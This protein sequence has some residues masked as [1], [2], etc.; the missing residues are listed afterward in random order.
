MLQPFDVLQ[1][2]L[3]SPRWLAFLTNWGYLLLVTSSFLDCGLV[4][5]AHLRQNDLLIDKSEMTWYLKLGWILY[6]VSTV[7]SVTITL[8]FYTLLTP[9]TSPN[10]ILKHAINSVYALSNFFICAKPFRILHAFHSMIFSF[11]YLIFSVIYQE[12]TDDVIYEILDWTSL[13]TAP[14]LGIGTVIIV[15]PLVHVILFVLYRVRLLISKKANCNKVTIQT[16]RG[17]E[18]VQNE[19]RH[20]ETTHM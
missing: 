8:L 5:F 6:N 4:L 20:A 2:S 11:T 19:V 14:L 18:S 12:I 15:I 10:S 17:K 9:G 3:P 1:D 13:P 16:E 7:L